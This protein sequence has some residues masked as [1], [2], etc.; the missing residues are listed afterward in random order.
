MDMDGRTFQV[1]L[2][3]LVLGVAIGGIAVNTEAQSELRE[4]EQAYEAQLAEQREIDRQ[5]IQTVEHENARLRSRNGA[6]NAAVQGFEA[7]EAERQAE[8]DRIAQ[9]QRL[10]ERVAAIIA[11]MNDD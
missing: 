11:E 10:A 9:E 6:L 1:G 8:L 2:L 7:R 5:M 4:R 3:G